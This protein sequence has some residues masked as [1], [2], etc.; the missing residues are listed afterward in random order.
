MLLFTLLGNP[1]AHSISPRLHN[2]VFKALKLDA[3]YVR[4]AVENSETLLQTFRAMNLSGAN[5]TVP[6]KEA[7]YAQCDEVRGLAKQIGAVNTLVREGTRVIG[8][9]TDAEGF[10]M[11]IQAF[12]PLRDVLILGAGGTAKALAAILKERG[13][14]VTILNRSHARLEFFKT[15]GFNVQT[16]ETFSPQAYDLIVNTTSAGLKDEALPCPLAFLETILPQARFAYDVIYNKPTPFLA[17][18]KQKNLTCKDGKE[19]LL[20]QAVLAFDLFF[21]QRYDRESVEALMRPVFDL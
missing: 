10:Y 21:A 12:E 17:L 3:C 4:K 2:S 9:N 7:A 11:S 8:Y 6:H 16:W 18:A 1:V 5:V 15:Q 13:I 20:Y 19:M 14:N